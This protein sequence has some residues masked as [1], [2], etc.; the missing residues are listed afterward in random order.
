VSVERAM[1]T[2]TQRDSIF[3]THSATESAKLRK[4]QMMSIRRPPAA[5]EARVR[6]YKL[7]V[8]TVAVAARFAKRERCFVDVPG[9]R[10][11]DSC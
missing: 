1:V 9:N 6:R 11:V 3:V 2:P 7:E 4:S 8:R 5:D 10:I